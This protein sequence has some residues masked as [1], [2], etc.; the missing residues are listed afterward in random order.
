MPITGITPTHA[1]EGFKYNMLTLYTAFNIVIRII[2]TS[3]IKKFN[4]KIRFKV[5]RN[6]TRKSIDTFAK[7]KRWN[8]V[9][10]NDDA[11]I[12]FGHNGPC[13]ITCALRITLT[14]FFNV[15]LANGPKAT[16]L[17]KDQSKYSTRFFFDYFL[18]CVQKYNKGKKKVLNPTCERVTL[19]S[20]KKW[21]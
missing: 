16:E 19:Q 9:T 5:N 12:L 2:E 7:L 3:E 11:I 6:N 1:S 13:W 8:D 21:E 17:D 4:G 14:S 15:Q 10:F 18:S 20:K